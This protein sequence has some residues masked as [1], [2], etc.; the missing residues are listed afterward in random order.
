MTQ[1][2]SSKR[3]WGDGKILIDGEAP[4][5]C[6]PLYMMMNT[7]HNLK[8]R[9]EA[10]DGPIWEEDGGDLSDWESKER[11]PEDVNTITVQV[12]LVKKL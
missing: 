1:G 7:Q 3:G 9:Q 12:I 8:V 11:V 4:T 6:C 2:P 5:K 10:G